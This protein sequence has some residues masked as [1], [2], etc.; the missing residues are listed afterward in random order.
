[1][2]TR[3]GAA[4]SAAILATTCAGC[5]STEPASDWGTTE[6]RVSAT[7]VGAGEAWAI[8]DGGLQCE[9]HAHPDGRFTVQ[10]GVFGPDDL[11]EFMGPGFG[12]ATVAMGDGAVERR[13]PFFDAGTDGS[14]GT[15]QLS[16]LPVS[17]GTGTRGWWYL[18]DP[19]SGDVF[20]VDERPTTC[21]VQLE[22]LSTDEPVAWS[23][24][25]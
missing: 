11:L 18:S 23:E 19:S 6:A 24:N 1:M 13:A 21:T 16:R 2:H 14:D 15:G 10:V 25:P 8:P 12:L 22:V 20:S 9:I 3:I 5:S 17:P 7:V 4:I